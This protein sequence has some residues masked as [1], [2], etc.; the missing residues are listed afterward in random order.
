M[1]NNNNTC[2]NIFSRQSHGY[3]FYNPRGI[4]GD[5]LAN[6]IDALDTS[7]FVTLHTTDKGAEWNTLDGPSVSDGVPR[8]C[9]GNMRNYSSLVLLLLRD[10]VLSLCELKCLSIYLSLNCFS[11]FSVRANCGLHLQFAGT[12]RPVTSTEA[13]GMIVAHG[14]VGARGENVQQVCLCV[15]RK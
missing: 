5:F 9:T 13:V 6:K 2:I 14:N 11:S 8:N 15:L 7:I 4:D 10:D 3:D 12:L 1:I